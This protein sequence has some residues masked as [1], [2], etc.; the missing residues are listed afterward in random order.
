MLCD[1]RRKKSYGYFVY[2]KNELV[3]DDYHGKLN[4]QY[5]KAYIR[6]G[7]EQIE[8]VINVSLHLKSYNWY[9]VNSSC[10]I[11]CVLKP[12]QVGQKT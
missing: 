8:Y 10:I 12:L 5:P 3:C 9:Q 11:W 1:H 2:I 4:S 7:K 6:N